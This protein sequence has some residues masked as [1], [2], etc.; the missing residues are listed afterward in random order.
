VQQHRYRAERGH[1]TS[2]DLGDQG[3]RIVVNWVTY[4]VSVLNPQ[5]GSFPSR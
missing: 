2:G 3:D 5:W 1:V 4:L